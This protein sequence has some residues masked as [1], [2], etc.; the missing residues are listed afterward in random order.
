MSFG[1]R[2]APPPPPTGPTF[3]LL[4][5]FLR[6]GIATLAGDSH[7]WRHDP[8]NGQSAID[9]WL[10]LKDAARELPDGSLPI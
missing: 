7:T 5:Q 10:E 1:R 9:A 3:G 2:I 4:D 6:P 8:S